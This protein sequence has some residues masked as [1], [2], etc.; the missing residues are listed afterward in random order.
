MLLLLFIVRPSE[1]EAALTAALTRRPRDERE[2]GREAEGP[3]EQKLAW[4]TREF[5]WHA[6][7]VGFLLLLAVMGAKAGWALALT[8]PC[9]R[10]LR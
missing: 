4:K 9:M 10:T 6:L 8:E 2:G 7:G 3:P 1:E 5:V